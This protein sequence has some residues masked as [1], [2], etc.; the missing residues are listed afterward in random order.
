M[1]RRRAVLVSG[2][3]LGAVLVCANAPAELNLWISYYATGIESYEYGHYTDADVLLT[4]ASDETDKPSDEPYRMADTL[5]RAG[6]VCVAQQRYEDAECF[7][8]RALDLKE[9]SLGERSRPVPTTLNNMAD[10][11]Y[12][13]GREPD[14]VENL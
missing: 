7:Y 14:C 8:K 13:I 9:R 6:M 1:S 2:I 4:A 10:L 11:Y 5:D 12:V 3:L